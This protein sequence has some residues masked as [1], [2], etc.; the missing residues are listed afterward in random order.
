MQP[1]RSRTPRTA[2]IPTLV[3]AILFSALSVVHFL[4]WGPPEMVAVA[5]GAVGG[6]TVGSAVITIWW[7]W[8]ERRDRE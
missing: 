1:P 4:S 3:A 8:W 5:S 7:T 6:F 2:A